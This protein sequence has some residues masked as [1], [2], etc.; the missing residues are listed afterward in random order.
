[1]PLDAP[2]MPRSWHPLQRSPE[3]IY[4]DTY[5]ETCSVRTP[6][7]KLEFVR[8]RQVSAQFRDI[9]VSGYKQKVNELLQ[10]L[11]TNERCQPN[12]VPT[13]N[14][15]YCTRCSM[16]LFA[17]CLKSGVINPKTLRATNPKLQPIYLLRIFRG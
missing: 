17:K 9:L 1:M 6:T 4:R 14:R 2:V 15:L 16:K 7:L 8:K 5:S 10:K 3:A 13:K 12:R 11:S